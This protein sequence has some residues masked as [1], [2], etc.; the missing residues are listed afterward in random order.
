M[1]G[2]RNVRILLLFVGLLFFCATGFAQNEEKEL[3]YD[4]GSHSLLISARIFDHSLISVRFTPPAASVQ[5]C[6]VKYFIADTSHGKKFSF[7][8]ATSK[9]DEPSENI[10]GPI[11]LSVRNLG[12]NSLDLRSQKIFVRGDFFFVLQLTDSSPAFGGEENPPY[13]RRTYY[14]ST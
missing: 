6:E 3:F 10:F 4:D 9:F 14:F 5:I 8:I 7:A 11:V 12:W 13:G 2:Q 1:V